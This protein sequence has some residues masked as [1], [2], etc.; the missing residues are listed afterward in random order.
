MMD[1][2]SSRNLYRNRMGRPSL[3][4]FRV[5]IE[6]TD[7]HIQ[8][9]RNRSVE[10]KRAV[11]DIRETLSSHIASVPEFATSLT[12][13]ATTKAAAPVIRKMLEAGKTAGVGPMAAVAGAVAEYCGRTL[14]ETGSPEVIVENGGD[15]FLSTENP[16]T[17]GIYA[18]DSVFSGKLGIRVAAAPH[19]IGVC[20]SSG[21][22]G[23]SV[24]FG[25]ADAVCVMAKDTALADA[26]ATSLANRIRSEDDVDRLMEEAEPLQG[27]LGL[28]AIKGERLGAF[29]AIEIVRIA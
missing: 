6:E 20:T 3:E 7:L 4:G 21:T 18:G 14:L 16:I 17:L 10:A 25:R 23:H 19:G 22:L 11:S 13:L 8:A 12:P 24:S 27:I 5:T 26:W 29:G 2:F 9:D 28:L 1:P 15:I